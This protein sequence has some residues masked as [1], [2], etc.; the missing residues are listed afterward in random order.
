MESLSYKSAITQDNSYLTKY[1]EDDDCHMDD[2]FIDN[3][4][5]A[6]TN[7][8]NLLYSGLELIASEQFNEAIRIFEDSIKELRKSPETSTLNNYRMALNYSNIALCCF[9]LNEFPSAESNLQKASQSLNITQNLRHEQYRYLYLKIL[10]N[11]IVLFIKTL[12]FENI[13]YVQ[14]LVVE[15]IGNERK[16]EVRANYVLLVVQIMFKTSSLSQF[17]EETEEQVPTNSEKSALMY[18]LVSGFNFL[19]LSQTEK[20]SEAFFTALDFSQSQKNDFIT[21]IILRILMHIYKKVPETLRKFKNYY[22]E[23]ERNF[24]SK[25]NSV[26]SI[27]ENFETK[28]EVLI[29]LSSVFVKAEKDNKTT[30][31][32]LEKEH[33]VEVLKLAA[34]ISL[35][36]VLI[37]LK[38]TTDAPKENTFKSANGFVL[39]SLG[40]TNMRNVQPV[41]QLFNMPKETN[42]KTYGGGRSASTD[43]HGNP[44]LQNQNV[45]NRTPKNSISH[46]APVAVE[47]IT[48][49]LALLDRNLSQA[50]INCVANHPFMKTALLRIKW[51]VMSVWQV[52]H[53]LIFK[54]AFAAIQE[55]AA[56]KTRNGHIRRPSA[57]SLSKPI[58]GR[59]PS[60]VNQVEKKESYYSAK[61][62]TV[63][64]NGSALIKLHV[65]SKGQA[66][67][68]F[69]VFNN[70]ILR[71]GSN[72]TALKNIR[73]CH[74]YPL[75]EIKG[76]AYG[77][78][79]DT[80]RKSGNR[81][82][83][84]W[85]CVS[86]ILNKRPLDLFIDEDKIDYWYIGLSEL[87]KFQN[88][89]AI[90][91]TKGKYFWM[92]FKLV[93][94]HLVMSH[95]PEKK[96]RSIGSRLTF[97]R[98]ILYFFAHVK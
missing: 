16:P 86:L 48:K 75:S 81:E 8:I 36:Q 49:T 31:E 67:R 94:K 64:S 60:T 6:N 66:K 68:Y 56:K 42:Y 83:E 52:T 90:C 58:P 35:R 96:R 74:S 97:C 20:S 62:Q 25:N 26:N 72:E 28:L 27:F 78:V 54:N 79:T 61:S 37:S 73:S 3:S 65:S 82:L 41:N 50:T 22:V 71:W 14:N 23:L 53:K 87:I 5:L 77:H 59:I 88:P 51:A 1:T 95:L 92:K 45:N 10:C 13:S 76:L 69:K 47:S 21:L 93:V 2:S 34:R 9:Y 80:F 12:N 39:S 91:L 30:L 46:L 4:L 84:P 40:P 44:S 24:G 57:S 11:F 85:L 17:S 55:V 98:A 7:A 89:N 19:Y 15:F 32:N 33:D 38:K 18:W 43:P 29:E 70:S 63:V